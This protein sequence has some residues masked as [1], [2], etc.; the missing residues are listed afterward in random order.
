MENH[1]TCAHATR[2]SARRWL[3]HWKL[4]GAIS[5]GVPRQ[6][7]RQSPVVGIRCVC[8]RIAAARILLAQSALR[9]PKLL[10]TGDS[11]SVVQVGRSAA[12]SVS[13][14]LLQ[15][16]A[17]LHDQGDF[18]GGHPHGQQVNPSNRHINA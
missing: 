5:H 10:G 11:I 16:G 14:L 13:P 18:F 9:P 2:Y 1:R 17:H 7:A 8:V 3:A 4:A 12:Q 15:E 6:Q